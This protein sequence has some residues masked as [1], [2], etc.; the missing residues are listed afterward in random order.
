M[1]KKLKI[2]YKEKNG[3]EKP[4]GEPEGKIKYYMTNYW[5]APAGKVRGSIHPGLAP[6]SCG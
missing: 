5:V 6:P 4:S 1:G 3:P 2:F